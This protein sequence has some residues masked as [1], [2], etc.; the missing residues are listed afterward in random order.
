MCQYVLLFHNT[1]KWILAK[2][3]GKEG[4]KKQNKTNSTLVRLHKQFQQD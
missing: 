1:I 2:K 4:D 3:E